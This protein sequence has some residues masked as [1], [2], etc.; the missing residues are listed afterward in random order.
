MTEESIVATG[1]CMYCNEATNEMTVTKDAETGHYF[2][3]E[4][5]HANPNYTD[6]GMTAY[7]TTNKYCVVCGYSE[8]GE[9]ADVHTITDNMNFYHCEDCNEDVNI[10]WLAQ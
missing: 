1:T 3:T 8:F 9:T 7:Y 2:V 4:Y 6:T 5:V 10:T